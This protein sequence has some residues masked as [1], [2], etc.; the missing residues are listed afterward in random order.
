MEEALRLH[1]HVSATQQERWCIKRRNQDR[2][3]I[4]PLPANVE[5]TVRSE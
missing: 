5:N 3:W 2:I 1:A 4:N